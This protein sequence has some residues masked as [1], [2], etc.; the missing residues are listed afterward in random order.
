MSMKGRVLA[1]SAE[2][3]SHRQ[4]LLQEVGRNSTAAES[5]EEEVEAVEAVEAEF[6]AEAGAAL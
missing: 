2:S 4:I 3:L 1:Q 5:E 6:A